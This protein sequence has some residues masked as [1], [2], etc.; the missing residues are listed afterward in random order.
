MP[1]FNVGDGLKVK[2]II[3]G[4]PL[5]AITMLKYDIPTGLAVP[6]EILVRELEKDGRTEV[7]YNLP[8][9]LIAGLDRQPELV[10]AA[11]V[12]DDKL[13]TLVKFVCA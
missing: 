13:E 7:L 5:I 3:L 9:G 11:K 4:N 1:L 6:V 2:R 10:E 8:S 12:L